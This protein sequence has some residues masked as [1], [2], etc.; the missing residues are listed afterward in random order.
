MEGGALDASKSSKRRAI[1][2]ELALKAGPS[3]KVRT[4]YAFVILTSY[5]LNK[6]FMMVLLVDYLTCSVFLWLVAI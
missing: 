4:L 5:V 6:I 2:A 3:V 1:L